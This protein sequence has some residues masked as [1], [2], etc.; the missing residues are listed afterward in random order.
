MANN[1]AF[2]AMGKTYKANA[3]TS[4]QRI[5]VTSDTPCNQLLVANH[6]PS[7]ATGNAVYFVVS[8]DA[9]VT[10]TLPVA[11]TPSYG[12]LSIPASNKVFTVPTQF[13][14]NSNIYIA[15]VGEGVSECYFTPGEGI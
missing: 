11:G 5:T 10:A 14:A 9:N 15:F 4:T 7:G 12:L 6:Q 2:Q 8:T 1:I 3:T 13:S